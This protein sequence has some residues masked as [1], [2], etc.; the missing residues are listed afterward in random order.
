MIAGHT[1]LMPPN[2][3]P[4]TLTEIEQLYPGSYRIGHGDDG[5]SERQTSPTR[6]LKT[7]A[8]VIGEHRS[9]IIAFTSGSTGK[10]AATQKSWNTLRV[11]TAHNFLA[12]LE[13]IAGM[14]NLVA[15]VPSQH[16]WGFET[17]VLLPLLHEATV[18][19]RNPL[20]PQDIANAIAEV[21]APAVLISSPLHL[22]TLMRSG[23]RIPELAKILTATGPL[24]AD[25]TRELEGHFNTRVLDAFG[26]TESG[27]IATRNTAREENWTL[28]PAFK[29]E[30]EASET[31]IIA[32][33]LPEPVVLPDAIELT[34]EHS[35]KWLGRHQDMINI[36]G[37][38]GSLADLNTRLVRLEGVHDGIIFQPPGAQR[39]AAMVVAPHMNAREV[40]NALG[41][42]VEPA[43]LPRPVLMVDQLPRQATGKLS[44]AAV[45]ELFEAIYLAN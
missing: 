8:P 24:S 31:R 43:F 25:E 2:R 30:P 4:A 9:A 37:K 45:V 16:M 12:L 41:P 36:A 15:T 6:D 35:F 23:V 38:R 18:S 29:L 14:P 7:D 10:P 34:G 13:D 1:T 17:S 5:E 33:H 11:G 3:Q 42:Q 27:V 44:Q 39:L 22:R 26:C 32:D 20:Y 28:G 19:Y 40:L 21:P